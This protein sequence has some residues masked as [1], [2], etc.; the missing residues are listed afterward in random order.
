VTK[1]NGLP[2]GVKGTTRYRITPARVPGRGGAVVE[3]GRVSFGEDDPRR[4]DTL[5]RAADAAERGGS[6]ED[7]AA[8]AMTAFLAEG[9]ATAAQLETERERR[10]IGRHAWQRARAS[11]AGDEVIRRDGGGRG[12][13]P[14]VWSLVSP[15]DRSPTPPPGGPIAGEPNFPHGKR[16][17]GPETDRSPSPPGGSEP[18]G[19]DLPPHDPDQWQ[20]ARR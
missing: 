1:C 14:A 3:V 12:R 2:E 6:A 8:A 19:G 4:A 10:G 17:P 16:D 15:P 18:I 13:G 11:L 20:E 5:V 7:Q 9:P